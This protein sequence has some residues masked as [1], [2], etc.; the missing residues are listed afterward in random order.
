MHVASIRY[1]GISVA[2][3]PG[4]DERSGDLGLNGRYC[5]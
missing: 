1:R 3:A 2:K 5:C 4:P